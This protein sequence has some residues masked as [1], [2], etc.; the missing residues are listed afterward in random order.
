MIECKDL[1][2]KKPLTELDV[3]FY[4]KLRKTNSLDVAKCRKCMLNASME[5]AIRRKE[6]VKKYSRY[7]LFPLLLFAL[8]IVE[9]LLINA[10]NISL[11]STSI[12][13]EEITLLILIVIVSIALFIA[14]IR[15]IIISFASIPLL[16]KYVFMGKSEQIGSHYEANIHYDGLNYIAKTKEVKDYSPSGLGI[17]IL[18]GITFGYWSVLYWLF[19]FARYYVLCPKDVRDAYT[20]AKKS[21]DDA[22]IH[23]KYILKFDKN[24]N[25]FNIHKK[26]T[27]Y[28]YS[29][30]EKQEFNDKLDAITK[31]RTFIKVAG[32]KALLM[33]T[34]N[35]VS[36]VILKE[37]GEIIMRRII[38]NS[39]IYQENI[40]LHSLGI[41][42][43]IIE[44]LKK[45][46][47]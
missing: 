21:V 19:C 36:T 26:T 12:T 27:S 37:N 9:I 11:E 29:Y 47:K 28:K 42:A 17:S 2:C 46:L 39:F 35:N 6:H 15:L 32:K 30:L 18:A 40:T 7:Y 20:Q 43:N 24:E 5:E 44:K 23:L 14:V 3:E 31:R 45:Q 13:L 16:R 25:L 10:E 1:V 38:D 22:T 33:S 8:I 41:P 34:N 4:K